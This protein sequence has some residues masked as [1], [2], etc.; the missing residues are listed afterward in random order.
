MM[1]SMARVWTHVT[2]LSRV[3]W[4]GAALGSVTAAI[5][6]AADIAGQVR[7]GLGTGLDVLAGV[8]LAVLAMAVLGCAV[9]VV[10]SVLQSWPALFAAALLGPFVLLFVLLDVFDRTL[11][12]TIMLD[13]VGFT[14]PPERGPA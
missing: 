8:V 11:S 10:R 13:A 4:P 12:G 5:L 7:S 1:V 9:I 14:R 6:F 2:F 3:A